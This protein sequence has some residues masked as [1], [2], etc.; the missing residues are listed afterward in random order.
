MPYEAEVMLY[1][2]LNNVGGL[3]NLFE[4]GLAALSDR[5]ESGETPLMVCLSLHDYTR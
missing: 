1:A 3:Q 4:R 2:R 5:N